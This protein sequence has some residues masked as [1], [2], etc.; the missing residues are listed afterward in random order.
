MDGEHERFEA[1]VLAVV[2]QVLREERR[3]D[4]VADDHLRTASPAADPDVRP[5]LIMCAAECL[6]M[7]TSLPG[8]RPR[9]IAQLPA[10][11]AAW[12]A[13]PPAGY[14]REVSRIQRTLQRLT[15][16]FLRSRPRPDPAPAG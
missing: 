12:R 1:A 11:V 9:L 2:G 15:T 10:M 14:D 13:L 4:L 5:D 8:G 3:V 6:R 16:A 7:M